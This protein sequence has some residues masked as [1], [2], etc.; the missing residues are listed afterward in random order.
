MALSCAAKEQHVVVNYQQEACIVGI[1]TS[2]FG[3][4][5]GKSPLRLQA[6]AF[7]EAVGDA[8]IARQQIDG[9][10]TAHGA[11]GGVDYDE[12]VLA[13]GL[14]IRWASQMSTHGRW[15]TSL[16]VQSALA[17]SAGLA[18]YIAIANTVGGGKSYGEQSR[19]LGGDWTREGLRD[20][21]GSHGE[22]DVHGLDTPGAATALV[23]KRYMQRYG[24][25]PEHLGTIAV[26][27]RTH[28]LG[29]PQAI[30]RDRPMSL[31]DY[32]EQ[33]VIVA[34]FRRPDYCLANG[35]STCLIITT[36]ERARDLSR[37]PVVVAG[38]QNIRASRDDYVLFSRPGLGVG[39]SPEGPYIAPATEE[40]YTMAGVTRKEVK[41]LY[42][43]DSFS[44]N[45]WMVLERFGFCGEG[46]AFRYVE[47][48]GIGLDSPLPVNTNG[49]LLSE[50]HLSGYAHLIEMVRQVR[51]EAG[52]RQI[53]EADVVQWIAPWGDSLI[54]TKA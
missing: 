30:M 46:E 33:P 47:S 5:L 20:V 15:A 14:N 31:T 39:I 18:N 42:C 21:G 3:F 28:A 16:V 29:N 37:A 17:V 9:L 36:R 13:A 11:P 49:G 48:E 51:G 43:Y 12:F 44:S 7:R 26:S 45:V 8:G 4:D 52:G 27:Q 23:A 41:G 1:G 32:L 54:F 19:M 24:A 22:W 10:C 6:E 40:V 38:F 53:S 34:P 2:E 35:G 25:T 50:G